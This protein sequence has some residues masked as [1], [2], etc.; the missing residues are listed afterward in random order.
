[1]N[2]LGPHLV[3]TSNANEYTSQ[4]RL[5]ILTAAPEVRTGDFDA[6][7]YRFQIGPEPVTTVRTGDP[8]LLVLEIK[9]PAGAHSTDV[10]T[11]SVAWEA[12]IA[13][14][15]LQLSDRNVRKPSKKVSKHPSK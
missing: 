1:M 12:I 2:V 13:I 8:D 14:E 5:R 4:E 15:L 10:L 6:Q 9:A 3:A 7:I 11:V